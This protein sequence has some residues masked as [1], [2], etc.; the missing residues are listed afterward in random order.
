LLL[1]LEE[2]AHSVLNV[3]LMP[4]QS[5]VLGDMLSIDPE[6]GRLDFRQALVSVARQNGKSVALRVLV[7]WW[8]VRMVH[9]RGES[10]TVLT[11]A[12]RLDLA[13]ELFNSLAEILEAKFDAKI[14]W[15]YGR[16]SATIDWGGGLQSRW[17]VRAATPS[18]GHGLSV[19]LCVID[20]LFDCSP[21][22]VDDAL[23]PTMRARRDPL[24]AMWSTAGT[25]ESEVMLRFRTRGM[26]EIDTKTKSR[27][28]FCEYSPPA[29]LN[30]LSLEAATWANPAL[31]I[32]VD[33]ETILDELKNPN[34]SATLRSV[35]NL[36]IT[37]SRSWLENGLFESLGDVEAMPDGGVLA[38]EA[39]SDDHRFVGVRAVANGETVLVT[40]EFIVD[41]LNDL[42]KSIEEC[43]QNHKGLQVVV[44]ASLDLHLPKSLHG[45][46]V[47]VGVKELQKWTTLV[48][49][50]IMSKQVRHTGESLLVEQVDRTVLSKH[51]GVNTISSARSPGPIELCRALVWAVATAGKPRAK[52][53]AAF[54]SAK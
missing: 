52:A 51:N 50:M 49:S 46:A 44:A 7:A 16:Q 23:I 45:R 33:E 38:V 18:A 19:D 15:S 31:G 39:S 29:N 22:A 14:V 24:L 37:S 35:C 1:D 43:K 9:I 54:A 30:P 20:E 6:T 8:L 13:T 10:Q 5:Q 41:N 40:V 25:T 42:W 53:T 36:W 3:N 26:A 4:W 12:H 27:L 47:L 34:T 17:I 32:T 28:Y 21:A 2:F 11:T 48:R